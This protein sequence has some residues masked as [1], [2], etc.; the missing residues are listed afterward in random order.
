MRSGRL[1]TLHDIQSLD[2]D[3]DY[4]Q[5][6]RLTACYE[7]PFDISLA[8]Q[9]SF[10][11]TYTI[12]SIAGKL[13]DTGEIGS[14]PV[15]RGEDTGLMLF[16]VIEHGFD[17]HRSRR[18]ISA[19]NRMHRRFAI[20]HDEYLFVLGVFCVPPMR[21]LRRYGWRAPC[22]HEVAACHAWYRHLAR[23]MNIGDVPA[24][25][26]E[27]ESWFDDYERCNSQ[28][29]DQGRALMNA[30]HHLFRNRFPAS[31]SGLGVLIGNALLDTHVRTALEY[32]SPFR[33]ISWAINGMFQARRAY[34]RHLASPRTESAFRPGG[35]TIGYPSGYGLHQLGA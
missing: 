27:L 30:S 14:R 20:S 32:P 19:M 28:A 25:F 11:R 33:P 22:C 23:L 8:L 12:P 13:A 7:F 34:V 6:Y 3:H 5:I 1:D 16:E 31:L 26:A 2:P 10:F 17:H 18:V 15:K 29:T 9:M 4:E 24:T 35:E 21:W